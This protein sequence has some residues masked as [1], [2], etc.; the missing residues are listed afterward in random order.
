[1]CRACWA[2]KIL[3][4]AREGG[5]GGSKPQEKEAKTAGPIN[6]LSCH[7]DRWKARAVITSHLEHKP[8][9]KSWEMTEGQ[10]QGTL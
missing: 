7:S 1:M 6:H 10:V 3:H 8:A 5:E 2:V 9:L 4:D